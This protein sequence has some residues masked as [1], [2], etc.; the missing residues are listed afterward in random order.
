MIKDIKLYREIQNLDINS[1]Q[2]SKKQKQQIVEEL[3]LILDICKDWTY[4]YQHQKPHDITNKH[5]G[6]NNALGN[7]CRNASIAS[8]WTM[9]NI[10]KH[11]SDCG[12]TEGDVGVQTNTDA[13]QPNMWKKIESESKTTVA[14]RIAS[15]TDT[16][17]EALFSAS[18]KNKKVDKSLAWQLG[19][20][21]AEVMGVKYPNPESKFYNRY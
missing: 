4:N 20:N 9:I 14:E 21:F 11:I 12:I 6:H 18:W 1:I 15:Y 17:Q 3:G 7:A 8:L 10:M 16:E 5:G 13:L 19:N 2:F